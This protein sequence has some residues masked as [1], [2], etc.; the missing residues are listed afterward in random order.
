MKV[1]KLKTW[2]T[3]V[4]LVITCVLVNKIMIF[5]FC[6]MGMP[7]TFIFATCWRNFSCKISRTSP[8]VQKI[9]NLETFI[10]II[11]NSAY[12]LA[13]IKAKRL[14]IHWNRVSE[15]LSDACNWRNHQC[16]S[17]TQSPSDGSWLFHST[18][19]S[20]LQFV[21]SKMSSKSWESIS[22]FSRSA[23]SLKSPE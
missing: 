20:I 2:M 16:R 9:S 11:I 18:L 21:S 22:N 4:M 3:N 14:A 12:H 5:L 13:V 10:T 17:W 19:H 7:I 6:S 1:F 23:M 8:S 15:Y